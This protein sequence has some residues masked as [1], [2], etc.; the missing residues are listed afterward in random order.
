MSPRAELLARLAAL[1]PD[2]PRFVE[3]RWMLLEGRCEVLG[4]QEGGATTPSLVAR[5]GEGGLV[6]VVGTPAASAIS[7]A[8]ARNADGGAL[9]SM[10]ENVPRARRA[11]PRWEAQPAALH[12]LGEGERLAETPQGE[13]RLLSRPEELGGLTSGLRAGL[14]EELGRAL[15]RGAAVAATFAGGVAVSFC[16][17]A[18]ETEGLWD[19]SIDTLE[20]YRR[21][22]HAAAC[23]AYMVRYMRGTTGKEP[24]WGAL[25]SNAASMGLAARLGF[26]VVDSYFVFHPAERGG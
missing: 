3:T 18:A 19:I 6:C 10:S 24:V 2:V 1:L 17:A 4:L 8:V 13:V 21:Q 11:L 20:G 12:R 14:R 23:A 5:G 9:I 7:D 15:R 22:G 25:V 16:Y 26:V